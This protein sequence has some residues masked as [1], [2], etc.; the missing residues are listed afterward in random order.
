MKKNAL[1]SIGIILLII[2]SSVFTLAGCNN[3]SD[4]GGTAETAIQKFSRY[5]KA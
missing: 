2:L 1:K 3:G 5:I 4:N